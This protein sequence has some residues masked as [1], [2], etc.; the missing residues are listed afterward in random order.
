MGKR[1]IVLVDD[2]DRLDRREIQAIFM[3]VKLSASFDFTS[4]VLA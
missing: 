2:I 3:L 4:Y 1:V